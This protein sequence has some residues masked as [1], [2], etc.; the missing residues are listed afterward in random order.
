[1]AKKMSVKINYEDTINYIMSS[2]PMYQRS[3]G[4]A[5][6]ANLNNTIAL[7]DYLN[8][9]QKKFKSVHIAAQTAR[10]RI[11]LLASIF[12]EAGYKQDFT[13]LRI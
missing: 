9:P 8:N 7:L 13:H 1:M 2:L 5:Y 12:Q 10:E 11:T 3:G 6:K 4:A